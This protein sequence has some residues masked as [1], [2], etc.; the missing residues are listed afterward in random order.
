[1][2]DPAK[3]GEYPHY[4]GLDAGGERLTG[5]SWFG[6]A[7]D[8]LFFILD[9]DGNGTLDGDDVFELGNPLPLPLKPEP[10]WD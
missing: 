1:M 7:K 5:H 9:A 3:P 10:H 2:R 8:V 4:H 6:R